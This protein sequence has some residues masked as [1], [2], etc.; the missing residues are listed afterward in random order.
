MTGRR[1]SK[2]AASLGRR[3]QII[4]AARNL[5]RDREAAKLTVTDVAV[6]ADVAPA[7]VYNLIGT[8][9]H[10]MVAVLESAAELIE[11]QLSP[12]DRAQPV[13]S[14]LNVVE[15]AVDVI[16]TDPVVHRRAIEALGE[17]TTGVW[18]GTRIGR[19]LADR[20]ALAEASF[21]GSIPSERLAELVHFGFRGVIISWAHGLVDDEALAP[22]SIEMALH[23]LGTTA[24]P[25]I[26]FDIK[27]RLISLAREASR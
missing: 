27:R 18:L 14:V 6:E 13:D 15:T 26:A 19:L 8:K 17:A 22:T 11:Q 3:H 4:E 10:L 9:E 1:P 12:A 20:L 2:S 23:V 5:L 21:D 25:D 7:T 16:T 24:R